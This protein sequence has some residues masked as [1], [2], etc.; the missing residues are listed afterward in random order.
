MLLEMFRSQVFSRDQLN[1]TC[2]EFPA[3]KAFVKRL[4][5]IHPDTIPKS[6][7]TFYHTDTCKFRLEATAFLQRNREIGMITDK[8]VFGYLLCQLFKVSVTYYQPEA[9]RLNTPEGYELHIRHENHQFT[10]SEPIVKQIRLSYGGA[11]GVTYN[12]TKI[13]KPQYMLDGVVRLVPPCSKREHV[14]W[15]KIDTVDAEIH[16]IQGEGIYVF[17]NDETNLLGY[18]SE[19]LC[20][21][22][23]LEPGTLMVVKAQSVEEAKRFI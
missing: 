3:V 5:L 14:H 21:F 23:I 1:P 20:R 15:C 22:F 16:T 11:K 4:H 2:Y 8:F 10:L 12:E 19:K 18:T 13:I 7:E 9:V 17:L 6:A